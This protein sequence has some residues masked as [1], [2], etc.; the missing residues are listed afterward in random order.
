M[1]FKTENTIWSLGWSWS[2]D[3]RKSRSWS[4]SWGKIK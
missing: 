3:Y 2:G 4:R 1:I